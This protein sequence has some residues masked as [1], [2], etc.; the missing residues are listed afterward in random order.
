MRWC[1]YDNGARRTAQIIAAGLDKI[2]EEW[3]FLDGDVWKDEFFQPCDIGVVFGVRE[4]QR[5]CLKTLEAKGVPSV[6]VDLGFTRRVGPNNW[7][8]SATLQLSVGRWL[9]IIPAHVC[10]SNRR[11][12]FGLFYPC[13]QSNP[14]GHDL[15]CGQWPS[16]PTHPFRSKDQLDEWVASVKAEY[17]RAIY[18]PHPRLIPSAKTLEEDLE[19]ARYV[20]TWSSN[21]GIDALIAGIPVIAKGNPPYQELCGPTF[22]CRESWEHYFNRLS[23]VQYTLE[24]LATGFP[25][26]RVKKDIFG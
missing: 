2:D 9:N 15:I 6:V 8:P 22:P 14:D 13:G 16:D 17:P 20:I 18:R 12:K 7:A 11:V 3:F 25:Q 26:A 10:P 1:L 19:G 23:Y 5:N 4:G 21:A 24:E